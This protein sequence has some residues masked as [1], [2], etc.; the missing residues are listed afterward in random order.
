MKTKISKKV[1]SLCLSLLI[2]IS[3]LPVTMLSASAS[4][5]S[6][7]IRNVVCPRPDAVPQGNVTADG[8]F[9]YELQGWIWEGDDEVAMGPENFKSFYSKVLNS[10]GG[11]RYELAK[12]VDTKK[13][14]LSLMFLIKDTY[15]SEGTEFTVTLY[16][17][18]GNLMDVSAEG[19]YIPVSMLKS[20]APEGVSL[21]DNW[22]DSD[23]I[24]MCYSGSMICSP[25]D[26]NHI[27]D[28]YCYD[29]NRHWH[30]C[31]ICGKKYVNSDNKHYRYCSGTES[32]ICINKATASKEGEYVKQ[33]YTCA[34]V[35]ERIT[36]PKT[37]EQTVVKSYDEL[38]NA[39]AKGGKQWITL[40][41]PSKICDQK[42]FETQNTL[43]VNDPEADITIDLNNC[44]LNRTTMY[45]KHL[46]EIKQGSL[47]IWQQSGNGID[48]IATGSF[49][50]NLMFSNASGDSVFYVGESGSLRLTNVH[51]L[52]VG[53]YAYNF[54]IVKS[55]GDLRI[56]SG[57]YKSYVDT[58]TVE[59]RSGNVVINGGQFESTQSDGT[60]LSISG[61]NGNKT[62]ATINYG[63]FGAY[64]TAVST[65]KNTDVTINGGKFMYEYADKNIRQKIGLYVQEGD[66]TING[67]SFYGSVYGLEAYNANSL[68]ITNGYFRIYDK[69]FSDAIYLI[70]DCSTNTTIS[71][72]TFVGKYGIE[73]SRETDF[74][75]IIPDGCFVTDYD[76]GLVID[77]KIATSHFG[78]I[79]IDALS[80]VITTQP[81]GGHSLTMGDSIV[82][83]IEADNAKEY[84]WHIIDEDGKELSWNY[85]S[86][87]G[88]ANP[89]VAS[90]GK[91]LFLYGASDWMTGKRVYCVAKGYGGTVMS[92]IVTLSVD[93]VIKYCNDL[94]F[95]DFDQI[96]NHKTVADFKNPKTD[97]DAPYTIG[98]V[99][100]EMFSKILGDDFEFENGDN[101]AVRI[102]VI[103][104]EGYTFYS[105]VYGKLNGIDSYATI[106]NEDGSRSI[107][108]NMTIT[109]PD[110]Y[111]TQ[112]IEL[113]VA[114]PVAGKT[115]A[116]T[117]VCTSGYA[118]P[119][120]PTWTPAD[121]T[122]NTNTEY[123]VKIPVKAEYAWG[124]T[125]TVTAK[126]NGKDATFI[127][128][129]KGAKQYAY[130]VEYTFDATGSEIPKD[131]DITVEGGKAYNGSGEEITKC[132]EGATVTLKANDPPE[133]MDFDRWEVVSGDITLA[134]ETDPT[135]T[136]VM[137]ANE[138]SV[139]AIYNLI[140][141][142]HNFD[143]EIIK[144]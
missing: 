118:V 129:Y 56:D 76:T 139:K 9:S 117:A 54:P 55:F 58:P 31:N 5:Y 100:W 14:S 120:T 20:M 73:C 141:H 125:S 46:F 121:E 13:Y 49:H 32:W 124:D 44:I 12:F 101:V 52:A 1:L 60:A 7:N 51:A 106:K 11:E 99:R 25:E 77:H 113:S 42:D 63:N 108:F 22:T 48:S 21:P 138:V 15:L 65:Y 90:G 78:S 89:Q 70:G 95:D 127:A 112:D 79:E 130:Y 137:P 105:S 53:D 83:K 33:C 24:L 110:E 59:V 94:Y 38:R 23:T 80:P 39:L 67:G 119:E 122:F 92:D 142:T 6:I 40:D 86:Y 102:D 136:F 84:T 47:R 41:F 68:N 37:G 36:V 34:Y 115:P 2:C 144:A 61:K 107:V 91:M 64:N 88:Y 133:G 85:L 43:C 4:S 19:N 27:S 93:K 3:A 98:N 57:V 87:N 71:G 116:T 26:H 82:L 10:S 17:E 126:V 69:T 97:T 75:K 81:S 28:R 35:M 74:S 135:T 66:L 123:T 30:E 104:K 103:P 143:S 16:D 111:K 72:G 62:T 131:Y 109:T 29:D 132:N 96:W 114:E 8:D 18:N 140:P 45:D 134:D 128:E 50:N